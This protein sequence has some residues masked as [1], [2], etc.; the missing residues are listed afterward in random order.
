MKNYPLVLILL[1]PLGLTPAAAQ[2]D[3]TAINISARG[4]YEMALQVIESMAERGDARAAYKLGLLYND[5]DEITRNFLKAA[6]YFTLAAAQDYAPAQYSLGIKYE[7]GQG[8]PQSHSVAVAWYRRSAEQNHAGA[9]YRLGRMFAQGRGVER[10]YMEAIKWFDLAAA[11]GI[12][13]A[14]VAREAVVGF[15]TPEQFADLQ[16][17]IS[18]KPV[19]LPE[20]YPVQPPAQRVPPPSNAVQTAAVPLQS[21]TEPTPTPQTPNYGN[22]VRGGVNA[23]MAGDYRRAHEIWAPLAE[24]GSRSAQFHLGALYFEGRGPTVDLSKAYYWLRISDYQG[25]KRAPSLL[26]LAAE[27]LT[28]D[29]IDTSDN[30]ARDWL[31]GRSIE[32]SRL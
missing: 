7:K 18:S 29:E 5:G 15:L 27:K 21:A 28:R 3:V 14:A 19:T 2:D 13:D 24:V 23:Y 4:D 9:Q 32:V 17:L 12:E 16:S 20:I 25:H 22:T 1:L 31:Q 26:A 10:D 8:V 11:Q 6:T 30:Q